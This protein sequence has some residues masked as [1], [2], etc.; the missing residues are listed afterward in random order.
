M[1]PTLI[2]GDCIIIDHKYY[3]NRSP[4]RGDVIIFEYPSD[5]AKDMM[6]R[7]IAVEG[8][9]IK[10][11]NKNIYLNDQL[12]EESYTQHTSTEIMKKIDNF[13]PIIVPEGTLF[14]M[15]DNRDESLDSRMFGVVRLEKVKGKAL[16][17]YWSRRLSRIG[18]RVK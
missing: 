10:G 11:Q 6:K 2:Q 3:R 15:G 13:G 4:K 8:D 7:V 9:V 18:T 16:Y 17:I 1:V 12:V 5:S 14:V